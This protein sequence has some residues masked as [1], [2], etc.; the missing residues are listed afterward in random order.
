[1]NGSN[2]NG[3]YRTSDT[4][5]AAYLYIAGF[6]IIDTDYTNQRCEFIFNQDSPELRDAIRLYTIGKGNVNAAAYSRILKKLTRIA[7]TRTP[8]IEGVIND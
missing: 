1:M 2:H 8:W 4:S 5:L 6:R 3:N 7:V